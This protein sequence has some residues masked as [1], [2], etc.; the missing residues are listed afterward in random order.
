MTEKNRSGVRSIVLLALITITIFIS[1]NSDNLYTAIEEIPGNSWNRYNKPVFRAEIIDTLQH[2][3]IYITLRNTHNY[4]FRNIFL[5]VTTTSPEGNNI[6]DT[7]EYIITDE[8]GRWLG[9]GLGDIHDL[10][11]PYKSN[12][13]FPVSGTYRFRIEQGMRVDDLDGIMNVGM[14]IIISEKAN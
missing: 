13:L 3:D 2:C 11:L 10:S 8:S 7:V 5:F 12:V 4:P 14:K 1:C 6:K 9:K